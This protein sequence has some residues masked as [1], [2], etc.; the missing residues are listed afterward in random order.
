MLLYKVPFFSFSYCLQPLKRLWLFGSRLIENALH[1]HSVRQHT[2]RLISFCV[3][4]FY[5]SVFIIF[6]LCFAISFSI[7]RDVKCSFKRHFYARNIKG[8]KA[9]E[10]FTFLSSGNSVVYRKN[11]YKKTFFFPFYILFL[12]QTWSSSS[13]GR[14]SWNLMVPLTYI[15]HSSS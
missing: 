14:T 9:L 6:V 2:H 10:M 5:C 13:H 12:N 15:L 7:H 3:L 11:R 4:L 1:S 8:N